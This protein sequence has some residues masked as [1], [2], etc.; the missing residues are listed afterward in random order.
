M[1][2]KDSKIRLN[3]LL[4]L[5]IVLFFASVILKLVYVGLNKKVEGIDLQALAASRSTVTKTIQAERGNIYDNSGNLLAQ[6]MNSYIVIAFL[7]SSRT[8][9]DRYPKHVVDK[10]Y[11]ARQLA[12]VLE[13][14][15]PIMTYEYILG[16]LSQNKVQVELGP[17]GRNISEYTKEKIEKLT[18]PGISFLK[19]TKRYYQ[20]GDFASYIVGYAKKYENEETGDSDTKGE[21]GIEG[22]CDEF[23]RGQDG[24]ITYSKDAYGYQM[25]NSVSY[26]E[27][28]QDG[29][30][31][32]LTID[33]QIQI[34]I[35]NAVNLINQKGATWITFTV[36]DAKTGAIV[37]SATSPSFNPNKL[38]I[39][40][41]NNPLTSYAYE[42]GS[43]MKIFSFMSAIEE[44]KYNGDA[45]YNSGTITVGDYKIKD[46]NN[47][48]WGSISYDV[49][50]TYSSNVAAVNLARS[51]GKNKLVDYYKKLGFGEKTGI[52]LANEYTGSLKNL[53]G[54]VSEVELATSSFGQGVTV[55]PIQ[56]IQALTTLTNDG[57]PLRPYVIEKVVNPNDDKVVYQ[58]KKKELERIYSTATVNKMIELMDLTVN[59]DDKTI[60]GKPYHSDNV[61][62]IGKT[63][64]ANYTDASGNYLTDTYKTIRSFAGIFPKENPEY[65]IYL[66]V[67]DFQGS[68]SD[69]GN[70]VKQAVESISKYKNIDNRTSDADETKIVNISNYINKDINVSVESLKTVKLNPIV[71][72]NGTKVVSQYPKKGTTVSA[73][74]KVFIITNGLSYTMPDMTGWSSTEFVD[75]CNILGVEYNLNGYGYVTSTSIPAGSVIDITQPID[76][77]CTTIDPASLVTIRE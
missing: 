70:A 74:T 17:G 22:Y 57:T 68:T 33:K 72:G 4:I 16:L 60:T 47:F 45:K 19:T 71:I 75:F 27:D 31:V 26:R 34:F 69:M 24:K 9:D 29:Y 54:S 64:T 63:G 42:P 20:N 18:L 32:Y 7:S 37:G 25:A 41:Y 48:G 73:N 62:I 23:L 10:D 15:S 65:I 43:T 5:F 49:G 30:D 39:T 21:L 38:N 58:A 67:K 13:P 14:L 36:A 6:N 40:N 3:I 8:V 46:W 51:I 1:K 55:T 77:T 50:F 76:A 12:T 44:G 53:T 2:I 35:D 28:A 56:M 59:S 61:R 11:T 52:E 66:A